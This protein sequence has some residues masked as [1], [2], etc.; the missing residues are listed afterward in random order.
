MDVIIYLVENFNKWV[1]KRPPLNSV[2]PS[3]RDC[4][5]PCKFLTYYYTEV[6]GGNTEFH[7]DVLSISFDLINSLEAF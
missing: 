3:T 5:S 4:V 7:R 2:I 1:S 6:H